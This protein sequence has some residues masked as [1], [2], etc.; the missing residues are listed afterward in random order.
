LFCI[1]VPV[2]RSGGPVAGA[3]SLSFLGEVPD[4]LRQA[5]LL[6]RV[7]RIGESALKPVQ[8]DG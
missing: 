6:A 1:A 7:R 2:G 8:R 5:Q 4:V 3:I